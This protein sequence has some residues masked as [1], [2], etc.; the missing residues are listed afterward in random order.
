M[1]TGIDE[2]KL[3]ELLGRAIVDFG[4][5][6]LTPLVLIGD[7]LGL[8]QT[9]KEAG[10]LTSHELADRSQ[11]KERYVREWLNAHAAS[12]YIQYIPETGRYT[13]TAEQALMFADE[14]GPAFVVGGFQTALAAGRIVDTLTNAFRTGEGIGWHEHHHELFHGTARFFRPSYFAHL[15][16][17]WIPAIEG[18]E[19]KLKSGIR[20][21]DVGCGQ[22]TST[23]LMAQ[24]YPNSRF[25]GFDYHE[26][27]VR[28]ATEKAKQAGVADR[29]KFEIASA[30]NIPRA[31]YD[32]ITVF[33]ALHDM[34]D[35]EGAARHILSALAPDGAWMIVEPYAGDRVEENLNPVGRA[36]YAAST[37]ICTPCSLSQEV[38]L[39]LG[40]Q[41][42]EARM[43]AVITRAGFTKFRRATQTPFNLVLEARP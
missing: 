9:L 5:A 7:R 27:S 16:S 6:S 30:K 41:A 38:G 18:M 10:P 15:T 40:A 4:G 1:H 14:D 39:A 35:P 33:D 28:T 34:G 42:G 19:A 22:G 3:T 25:I 8:Y 37:L 31:K 13:L 11:T 26:K 43:R 20:V 12:G 24:Q 23:I 36:Y 29:C 32:F 2:N 21:A 17:C